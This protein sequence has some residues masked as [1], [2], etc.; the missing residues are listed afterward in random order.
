MSLAILNAW[1]FKSKS[2]GW[3]ST[4]LQRHFAIWRKCGFLKCISNCKKLLI[5]LQRWLF[6]S[7]TTR[8][9]WW[10]CKFLLIFIFKASG[11]QCLRLWCTLWWRYSAKID[12]H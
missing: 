10:I 9:N 6:I 7:S 2:I 8:Q 4:I 1:V 5:F 3:R 12:S 11:D